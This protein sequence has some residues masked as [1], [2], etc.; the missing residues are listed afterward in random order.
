MAVT[1]QAGIDAMFG[2]WMAH[3]EL[4]LDRYARNLADLFV[5]A[6]TDHGSHGEDR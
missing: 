6:V 5:A 4:D 1:H 3:P 2:Y